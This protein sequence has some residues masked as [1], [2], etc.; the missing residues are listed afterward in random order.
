[1]TA[2]QQVVH[3]TIMQTVRVLRAREIAQLLDETDALTDDEK[4]A[5]E[6]IESESTSKL[7]K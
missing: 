4:K 3:D 6:A 7:T 5:I 2:A 1:M